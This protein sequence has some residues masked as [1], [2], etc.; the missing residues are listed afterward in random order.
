MAPTKNDNDMADDTDQPTESLAT[1]R[2]R[3]QRVDKTGRSAALERFRKAK[4]QGSKNKYEMEEEKNVYDVVEEGEYSDIVRQRQEDDWIVD[5]DG[6]GY[7]EDGR[8]IFDDD[9]DETSVAKGEGKSKDGGKK[10]NKNI[11][12]PG[13]KPKKD[14]KTMFAAAA[15]SSKKKSEKDVSVAGDDILGDLMQELKGGGAKT[16]TPVLP[17]LGK[18]AKAP[19]AAAAAA[20]SKKVVNP[21]LVKPSTQKPKAAEA[22]TSQPKP[23]APK[24]EVK[25]SKR[26]LDLSSAP[27]MAV[28]QMKRNRQEV[29]VKEEPKEEEEDEENIEQVESQAVKTE[30]SQQIVEYNEEAMDLTDINFDDDDDLSMQ[31]ETDDSSVQNKSG[32]V[33]EE[34]P[35]GWESVRCE[36]AAQTEIDI[37]V[38]SSELPLVSDDDGTQ[39]LRFYWLDAFEDP[40]KQP[41]TVYLFGKVWIESAKA[42]VSCCVT[43]KNIER[44]IYILPRPTKMDV[45]NQVST[46]EPVT[47]MDV[48]QEFNTTVSE[49]HRISKFKSKKGT[50]KYAF[51]KSEVP[52][53]SDYLEVHYA[54][55]LPVLPSDLQGET[56]SHVFGTRTSSL[57][58]LVIDRKMKGPCWL[59]LHNV[60]P[61]NPSISWC[62]VEALVTKPDHVT[63][64]TLPLPPPP[65]V[66]MTLNLRTLPNPKTHQ[67]EVVGAAALIHGAFHMDKP[68]PN[69]IYQHY[70]SVIS[71]PSDLIFPYDFRDR[72]QRESKKMQV[73]VLPT[74]RALLGFLLAKIHKLDPDLIVGH[75]IYGFDLDILLH[76]ISANKIPHWSKIGR[77]KRSVMPKL[78]GGFGRATFAEKTAMCGRLLCD[79]KISAKELIRCKSYDL[80]ELVS[81]ILHTKRQQLDYDEIKEMYGTSGSLLKLVELTLMDS[82]FVLRILYELNVIPLA[83]QITA[84]CGNTMARTLMGGRS[85]RNEYLLLHAF[86]EKGFICPD[87]E[88]KQKAKPQVVEGEGEEDEEGGPSSKKGQQGRRKPAYAGGL[89]L[90]PKK[91]FYDKF[92]LLLDFNSLY[93]SIIQEYNICFT[94]IARSPQAQEEEDLVLPSA[95]L[96]PGILPT[97]IR[98]L[99]ES[100]R[101]VKQLMKTPDISHEQLM[102]YDIRQKAL[103]LT[104]NSMYGCLGFSHSR[105]YAKPLAA[106]V[107][108][109]GREILMKT[110]QLV[111]GMGLEVIYGDTDSI[112]VNTNSTDIEQ[113]FK[114]GNRVKAEVNRLYRL[115]EIDIDGVFKSMLLL[116]KKKYA[117]LN[118]TKNPDGSY[119]TSQE[120]K[121]LDIVRRDWCDLAK[122]AGNFVVTQILSGELRETVV[123]NIHTRLQEVGEKVRNNEL[124]LELFHITKQLMKN[125]EDYPD[126]KNQ[127]H[128]QVALRFNT[129]GGKKIRAGDTVSYVICADG[130]TLSATQRAY[131]PEELAKNDALKI[132]THYYLDNQI[133]PV[134]ARLCEPIEGTDRARLA[135]CLGLDPAPYRHSQQ[136]YGDADEED[137]LLAAL[138]TEEEKYRDCTRFKFVCPAEGCGMENVVDGVF[139]SIAP[140]QPS[141]KAQTCYVLAQCQ[142]TSCSGRPYLHMAYLQN[143]LLQEIRTHVTKYYAGWLKCEDSACGAR[144]R[145][146]PLTFHRGH[147]ICVVC[148]RGVLHREYSDSA[149]YTQLCFYQYIFDVEKAKT[150]LTSSDRASAEGQLL[151]DADMAGKV[152]AAY[153]TL[154]GLVDHWQRNN[155]Y[156]QV[157]LSSLFHGLF[158]LKQD[159]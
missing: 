86:T 143:R 43:V 42:H 30:A 41:G 4:E 134:V 82:T 133:L 69:P 27:K 132:D 84:I 146:L 116:K 29:V 159:K 60:Q 39:V 36:D 113:V 21:F 25:T 55:D 65:L 81:H 16:S 157:D 135:E 31:Q 149:L 77:L 145:K 107:T 68:A 61:V 52:S 106:L 119:S 15:A 10:K 38:D 19:G 92:I 95:D 131:H 121:G 73:E 5:D 104:A 120:L 101:Q 40:Y 147:P 109:K 56:F 72:V 59:D 24:Q 51:E 158:V 79:V 108:G 124:P 46:D 23:L 115:L 74:E 20:V 102:Q 130:S 118:M 63:V 128:V 32:L 6:G 111:E 156:S 144:M 129:K 33:S 71:K 50:K 18:Q 57:E 150:L 47:M 125:P 117:A 66:V 126:K 152:P 48:Y 13:T 103:K 97:E 100:R 28:S 127:S 93:P 11:V 141:G 26:S 90:E 53:E 85:E 140:D 123:D 14:I 45:K 98:K 114:L 105:F 7:V 35:T 78:S 89:V 83:L 154:K 99:V 17:K 96:D 112:M 137:A 54:A 142:R 64:H 8:E 2:S 75:D 155:A 37:Q 151:K 67:N 138:M 91:G 136:R 1:S 49:K 148:R 153:R 44:K 122:Q 3:R 139:T 58:N 94:T 110:K 80:T 9:M 87:K 34:R 62:K 70:F 76:R 12:R 22:P 88:F